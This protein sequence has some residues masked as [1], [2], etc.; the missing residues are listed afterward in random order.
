MSSISMGSGKQVVRPPQ[1]GIFP[2]DHE[3]SCKSK[4]EDYLICLKAEKDV[5][6]KCRDLSRDYLQCRMDH[7]LMARENLDDLGFSP[8][9]QVQGA[10][11]YDL[12]KE[13]EGF[14]AGK[15]IDKE[16]KWWWQRPWGKGWEN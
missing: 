8:D 3:A 16:S 13:K 11:E 7:Q 1:R 2:L 6:H 5:H 14:V 4:M 12:R 10:R 9:K 15:H